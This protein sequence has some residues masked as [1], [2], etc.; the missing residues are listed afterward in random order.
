[1]RSKGLRRLSLTT[2]ER[3]PKRGSAIS[4]AGPLGLAELA[5]VRAI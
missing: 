3:L 4:L 5:G 1:M 2:M